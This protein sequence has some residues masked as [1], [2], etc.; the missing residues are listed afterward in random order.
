M[1]KTRQAGLTL[2][3]LM[4]AMAL[5]MVLVLA[6][7]TVFLTSRQTSLVGN[8]FTGIQENAR[9]AT[10]VIGYDLLNAGHMGCN[11]A[12]ATPATPANTDA[13]NKTYVAPVAGWSA[14]TKPTWLSATPKAG[15]DILKVQYA[16]ANV[17]RLTSNMAS[18]TDTV[19]FSG[20]TGTLGAG[21]NVIADCAGAE[22]FYFNGVPTSSGQ[23]SA[24]L[25][26]AYAKNV[27]EIMGFTNHVYFLGTDSVLKRYSN[28]GLALEE[29]A[30]NVEDFAVLYGVDSNGDG[31]I[32][33][34]VSSPAGTI[35]SVQLC[36]LLTNSDANVTLAAASSNYVD[37]HGN[38][39]TNTTRT[40][41]QIYRTTIAVRNGL[42]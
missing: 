12:A 11:A 1:T 13:D 25:S 31:A 39:K 26:H 23:P 40:F 14:A 4:I 20:G 41:H 38:T 6:V 10:Q 30:D 35:K 8:A 5:S 15:T 24:A 34:Y 28:A 9:F 7:T 36:L 16:S 3:E 37:C 32:D 18:A 33:R 21:P 22:I 29:L 19:S 2:T 17:F 27:T 42:S